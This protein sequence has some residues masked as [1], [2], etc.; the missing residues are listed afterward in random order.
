M[1]IVRINDI[2]WQTEGLQFPSKTPC[3]PAFCIFLKFSRSSLIEGGGVPALYI[4]ADKLAISHITQGKN[5]STL[6]AILHKKWRDYDFK[7]PKAK[8]GIPGYI[9]K[10]EE[11]ECMNFF[12]SWDC[13]LDHHSAN[14][15]SQLQSLFKKQLLL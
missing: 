12:L 5:C 9:T 11:H 7:I 14:R 6:V 3:P 2:S 15:I 13:V 10:S 4:Y 1:F 8:S